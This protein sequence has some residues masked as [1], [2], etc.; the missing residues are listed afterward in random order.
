MQDN[1]C[2][3]WGC[4]VPVKAPRGCICFGNNPS[5]DGNTWLTSG[6]T[7]NSGE[8][9]PSNGVSLRLVPPLGEPWDRL[10]REFQV[11][12]QGN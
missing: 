10:P 1:I 8:R 7:G 4:T 12:D 3:R 11:R 2:V 9:C 6:E 5:C